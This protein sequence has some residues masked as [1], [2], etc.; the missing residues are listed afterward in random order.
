M[1]APMPL[2]DPFAGHPADPPVQGMWPACFAPGPPPVRCLFATANP[3]GVASPRDRPH[4][5]ANMFR[6]ATANPD[7]PL[8]VLNI[9]FN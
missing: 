1:S 9:I 5:Y 2:G 6:Q 3:S 8:G 7:K 4:A